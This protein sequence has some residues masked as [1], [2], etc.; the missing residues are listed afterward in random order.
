MP[1]LA[2]APRPGRGGSE[3]AVARSRH[4]L[5]LHMRT[6]VLHAA[7]GWRA[8]G[9]ATILLANTSLGVVDVQAAFDEIHETCH[10]EGV[11]LSVD[12]HEGHLR[13]TLSRAHV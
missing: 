8:D 2:P 1:L 4:E 3:P 10:V 9:C 13:A 7:P 5:L 12:E 6:V 11:D